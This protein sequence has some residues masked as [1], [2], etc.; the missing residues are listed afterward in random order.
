MKKQLFDI[1]AL[2]TNKPINKKQAPA[3]PIFFAQNV[4][5]RWHKCDFFA[6]L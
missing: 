5:Q 2:K 1:P 6:M 4:V 3:C